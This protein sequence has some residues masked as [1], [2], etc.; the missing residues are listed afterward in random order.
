M[1]W[2]YKFQALTSIG[3][4]FYNVGEDVNGFRGQTYGQIFLSKAGYVNHRKFY[5]KQSMHIILSPWDLIIIY[6]VLLICNS[7]ILFW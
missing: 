6:L 1:R 2:A 4:H 5:K 7:L 3:K